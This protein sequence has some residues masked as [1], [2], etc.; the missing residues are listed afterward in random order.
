MLMQDHFTFKIDYIECLEFYTDGTLILKEKRRRSK[1]KAIVLALYMKT[2]N[3]YSRGF[4]NTCKR[5]T[6]NQN[7]FFNAFCV[8][9]YRDYLMRFVE[10]MVLLR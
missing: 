9:I 2:T 3:I 4:R 6:R 8:K 1:M 5:G 7:M 10:E